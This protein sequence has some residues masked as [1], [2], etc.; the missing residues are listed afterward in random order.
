[1][2]W[3]FSL[4]PIVDVLFSGDVSNSRQVCLKMAMANDVDE[5]FVT[6]GVCLCEYD[7]EIRKPKFL[8]CSHTVCFL[9]VQEIRRGD[10][11]TCPFCRKVITKDNRKEV[12]WI[13]PNNTY[14]L[15]MLKLNKQRSV[16][17][18]VAVM[19][20]KNP[21]AL[22]K[23]KDELI[24]MRD[25]G[26]N[27]LALAIQKRKEVQEQVG[28]VLKSLC[29]AEEEVTKFQDE[30][31]LC[32]VEMISILE[33]N[34]GSSSTKTNP[35]EK[36]LI[37]SE[38][39]SL[40]EGSTSND[41]PET[42][43]QKM[44]KSVEMYEQKLEE[45]TAI[46]ARTNS[47]TKI[48]VHLTDENGI[49]IPT[50]GEQEI[51]LQPI[52][53][54]L[55]GPQ[56]LQDS[57][58]LSHTVVASLKRQSNLGKT[59]KPAASASAATALSV[60]PPAPSNNDRFFIGNLPSKFILRL[61]ENFDSVTGT[62]ENRDRNSLGVPKGEV[63]IR[64]VPTFHPEFVKQLGNFCYKSPKK[65]FST[66]D[67]AMSG[68]FVLF[69]M[70][71]SKFKPA[72]PSMIGH[73]SGE[74]RSYDQLYDFAAI[75]INDVGIDLVKTSAGKVIGWSFVFILEDSEHFQNRK[76]LHGSV[77]DSELFG[78]VINHHSLD[79]MNQLSRVSRAERDHYFLTLESQ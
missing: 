32:L 60:P 42:L 30:N 52:A 8:S 74:N 28:L 34:A 24:K 43:K 39:M 13:L 26:F 35:P 63:H 37:L 31:N 41:T 5:D 20:N 46:A 23:L 19:E 49:P 16:S 73:D 9:C 40:V 78:R 45:A 25:S 72:V 70:N 51:G 2:F 17:S 55:D 66:I 79:C 44:S 6:C 54:A 71:H 48:R 11:I 50:G 21:D 62:R 68:V 53:Q 33:A 27:K 1:M 77:S 7:E 61:F 56:I 3:W 10:T 22:W 36:D 69:S 76:N 29:A 64:P 15:Q 59:Q 18:T 38:L 67:K 75:D 58:L 12:E 57:I 65:F 47:K 4:G 14:A